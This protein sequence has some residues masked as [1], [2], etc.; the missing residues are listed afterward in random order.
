MEN[1]LY[2][3]VCSIWLWPQRIRILSRGSSLFHDL[4]SSSTSLTLWCLVIKYYSWNL[5]YPRSTFLYI[6]SSLFDHSLTRLLS[7]LISLATVALPLPLYI[8][9]HS[10]LWSTTIPCISLVSL[11]I[12]GQRS[13]TQFLQSVFFW[14]SV[15]KSGQKTLSR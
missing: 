6:V 5:P 14:L 2:A 4:R 9:F 7:L 10:I 8:R 3:F 12:S 13:S 15:S 11:K 1:S